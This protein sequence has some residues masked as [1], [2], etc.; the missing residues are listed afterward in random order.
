MEQKIFNFSILRNLLAIIIP[1]TAI[2]LGNF[3]FLSES[4]AVDYNYTAPSYRTIYGNNF[5]VNGQSPLPGETVYGFAPGSSINLLTQVYSNSTGAVVGNGSFAGLVAGQNGGITTGASIIGSNE[6]SVQYSTRNALVYNAGVNS[7][8]GLPV[9]PDGTDLQSVTMTCDNGLVSDVQPV[10]DPTIAANNGITLAAGESAFILPGAQSENCD[11]TYNFAT[12][13]YF[14]D[15]WSAPDPTF[16]GSLT[17]DPTVNIVSPG[18]TASYTVSFRSLSAYVG[19]VYFMYASGCPSGA[20]CG[21]DDGGAAHNISQNGIVTIHFNI[22]NTGSLP[23]DTFNTFTL[24]AAPTQN[25]SDPLARSASAVA[26]VMGDGTQNHAAFL[27]YKYTS[28]TNASHNTASGLPAIMDGGE[29]GTVTVTMKNDGTSAWVPNSNGIGAT[30]TSNPASNGYF[31]HSASP[32]DNGIWNINRVPFAPD[33]PANI[34]Y[35]K[36]FA[37]GAQYNSAPPVPPLREVKVYDANGNERSPSL[38]TADSYLPYALFPYDKYSPSKAADSNTG[39]YWQST[40]ASSPTCVSGTV[41]TGE[42]WIK[43]DLGSVSSWSRISLSAE[44]AFYAPN[45]S[46]TYEVWV[47]DT[48]NAAGYVK[49]QDVAGL[50]QS[51]GGNPSYLWHMAEADKVFGMGAEL[52]ALTV[53]ASGQDVGISEIRAYDLNGNLVVPSRVYFYDGSYY[54]QSKNLDP[55]SAPASAVAQYMDGNLSSGQT[56]LYA[57]GTWGGR[58][59][60]DFGAQ[61]AFKKIMLYFYGSASAPAVTI[62]ASSKTAVSALSNWIYS[63]PDTGD[64]YPI[65]LQNSSIQSPYVFTV[66]NSSNVLPVGAWTRVPALNQTKDFAFTIKAPEQGSSDAGYPS[67]YPFQWKMRQEGLPIDSS[68]NHSGDFDNPSTLAYIQ[69]PSTNCNIDSF[70]VNNAVGGTFYQGDPLQLAWNVSR[71]SSLTGSWAGGAVANPSGTADATSFSSTLGQ[72]TFTLTCTSANGTT[73]SKNINISIISVPCNPNAIGTSVNQMQGCVWKWTGDPAAFPANPD[74]SDSRFQVYDKA[75]NRPV[76]ALSSPVPDSAKLLDVNNGD[77]YSATGFPGQTQP[78]LTDNYVVVWGGK[79][80]FNPKTY[81]FRTGSDDGSKIYFDN[82]LISN[83]WSDHGFTYAPDAPVNVSAGEHTVHYMFYQHGG[84]AAADF[85]WGPQIPPSIAL[86]PAAMTFSSTIGDPAPAGQTL[87]VINNG[88]MVLNWAGSTNQSWCHLSK[89]SGTAAAGGGT[90]TVTVSV[91]AR[92]A[93]ATEYCTVTISDQGGLAAAQQLPVTDITYYRCE[94]PVITSPASGSIGYTTSV[95]LSWNSLPKAAGYHIRLDYPVVGQP[96]PDNT[97]VGGYANCYAD[98]TQNP[99]YICE[100]G[101]PASVTS[102]SNVPVTP[103]QSYVFWID[104]Y[105]PPPY[106]SAYCNGSVSFTVAAAKPTISLSAPMTFY[107]FKGNAS[108]VMVRPDPQTLTITNTGTGSLAWT[109][110]TNQSWCHLSKTSGTAAAGGGTDTVS[111]SMDDPSVG[112]DYVCTITITD[113]NATNPN[114]TVSATYRVTTCGG[115]SPENDV[116]PGNVTSHTVYLSSVVNAST[117]K[118]PTWSDQDG[119]D[120]L[121]WYQGAD[122]GGGTWQYTIDLNNHEPGN[123]NYGQFYTHIYAFMQNGV[124]AFCGAANFTW[125]ELPPVAPTNVHAYNSNT[126]PLPASDPNRAACEHI[127]VAWTDASSDETGFA[128]YSDGNLVGTVGANITSYTFAVTDSNAHNY[129]VASYRNSVYSPKVSAAENPISSV[130]CA[131]RMD[132][133]RKDIMAVNGVN[134]SSYYPNANCSGTVLPPAS[135][136]SSLKLGDKIKFAINLCNDQG[137][138]AAQQITVTDTFTNMKI[139]STGLNAC[140]GGIDS[141]CTGGT[142]I[143]EGSGSGHYSVSGTE[144]NQTI[145]FDLSGSS[146]DIPA[147]AAKVLTMEAELA[148][149]D[150]TTDTPRF[151][152]YARIDYQNT[153]T[154]STWKN[155]TTPLLQFYSGAGIPVIKEH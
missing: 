13:D 95:N 52:S 105:Y 74:L 24:K 152:N 124:P 54:G 141:S 154:T 11:L 59:V 90:D 106:A 45:G 46:I 93:E 8:N 125:T 80:N 56:T 37:K 149:S 48:D 147:G 7:S 69:V 49:L 111:V 98:I 53:E 65:W 43:L 39:T 110:S 131:A 22:T 12:P 19:P 5:S 50:P 103:G 132:N 150:N 140:F 130:T 91:D 29:T 102:L 142:I 10:T 70:T 81:I 66:Y 99:H 34:R 145:I 89:A 9:G 128:I 119:Q 41:C 129:T 31:L 4:Y 108:G 68:G 47:S 104:P 143:T 100:N 151:R 61:K 72:K 92:P 75:P 2:V 33:L 20:S 63:D 79:F 36:I 146:F 38:V 32:T 116:V 133:S 122:S 57:G 107:G 55:A 77:N 60:F 153:S 67:G 135:T 6:N 118:F 30:E 58:W 115:G 62:S 138:T 144:P 88:G 123:P 117:V 137:N 112:G 51:T 134:F 85:S 21:F 139:P 94:A 87:T 113:P 136:L 96:K 25:L 71:A 78:P 27:G 84:G 28:N 114:Q 44:S 40:G 35:V 120:D 1:I 101:L 76:S 26:A 15:D 64:E 148:V 86:S 155:V 82:N 23:L 14:V 16:A 3:F 126:D 121:Q 97:N 83:F 73:Q 17:I 127:R 18:Q 42:G 109:G